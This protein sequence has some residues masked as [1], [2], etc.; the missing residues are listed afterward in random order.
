M[1]RLPFGAFFGEPRSAVDLGGFTLGE[2][3]DRPQDPIF[4]HT[5]EDA[6]FWFVLRGEYISSAAGLPE[7]CGPPTAIFVPAGTTHV[8]RFHRRGGSF[9]TLSIRPAL[10]ERVGGHRALGDRAVGFTRGELP[11]LGRRLHHELRHADAASP[12]VM[13]GLALEL[14]AHAAREGQRAARPGAPWLRAAFELVND[15][16]RERLTVQGMAATLGVAPLRLG[17]AFRRAFG[18]S[19]GEMMRRRRVARAEELLR[20]GRLALAD[21]ALAS[22]F[23][24]QPQLTKAFRR[25]TGYTPG[26]YRR[27]FCSN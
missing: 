7:V 20:K 25:V 9:M 27:L 3:V 14:L 4:P 26:R 8:D 10:I 18:C 5:H 21:I 23:A 1:R 19:P 11:W 22:G 13:E 15:G 12:L 16:Y 2:F 24:D 17:R 6:H